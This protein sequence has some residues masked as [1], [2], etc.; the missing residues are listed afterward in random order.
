MPTILDL[1]EMYIDGTLGYILEKKRK[2]EERRVRKARKDLKGANEHLP[3]EVDL[4]EV[5]VVLEET[6]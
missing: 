5:K 2:A 4:R 1:T 6:K 3:G